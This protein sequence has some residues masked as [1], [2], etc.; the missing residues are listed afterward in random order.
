MVISVLVRRLREG[1]TYEDFRQAWLPDKGFGVPTRVVTG[2]KADDD[3]EIITIGFS[4][5]DP[6]ATTE[7]LQQIGDQEQVRHDRIDD[8]VEPGMTRAFYIQI[9]DDDLTNDPPPA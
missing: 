6:D 3:R 9:A 4:A 5:L 1:K 2:Q 7:F 8:V